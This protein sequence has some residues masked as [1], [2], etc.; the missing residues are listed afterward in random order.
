MDGQLLK[1]FLVLGLFLV[2][3]FGAIFG[4]R[5]FV[6]A[7]MQEAVAASGP[8]R[9]SVRVAPVERVNWSSQLQATATLQAVQGALLTPQREGL[10]TGIHF[11]SG[12]NVKK[13]QLLVQLDDASERAQLAH[14]ESALQLARV[15]LAQQHDLRKKQQ[16]Q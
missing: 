14:D 6:S 1:R 2:A 7:K 12:T 10:V 4:W 5:T 8:P 11:E 15:E 3:L 13:G 9:V 16:Y